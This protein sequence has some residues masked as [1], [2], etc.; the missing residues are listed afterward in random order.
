MI[1]P[2]TPL[3][4][5]ELLFPL[6]MVLV[7]V[8]AARLDRLGK[9]FG[10][11]F[12]SVAGGVASAYVFLMVLPKLAS[13]QAILERASSDWPPIT[14][15]YDHAYFAAMLGFVVF[16]KLSASA[17]DDSGQ[18]WEGLQRSAA[19]LGLVVY[20]FLV[21][22][23]ISA[24]SPSGLAATSLVTLALGLHVLGLYHVV[25]PHFGAFWARLRWLLAASVAAGWFTGAFVPIQ[26]AAHAVLSA[27]LAGGI[28]IHV[29]VHELPNER[30]PLAFF[31]GV[32]IF[33]LLLKLALVA[34]GREGGI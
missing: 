16:Y 32:G 13:Q 12:D 8:Y 10:Q 34:A 15:L 4:P 6:L 22:D 19:T 29:A 17:E 30:R 27:F 28:I 33:A 21:G 31:V 7:P 23:A 26:E 11:G 2:A 9:R 1:E 20:S 24:H 5:I 25:Y 14:Y 18:V 3:H